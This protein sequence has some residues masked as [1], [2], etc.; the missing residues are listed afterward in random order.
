ML[1]SGR[2]V[3]AL[4]LILGAIEVRAEVNMP[5]T[6]DVYKVITATP[7]T[8][9]SF[10]RIAGSSSAGTVVLTSAGARS[11]TGG[12]SLVSGGTAA[13]AGVFTLDGQSS[14]TVTVTPGA[15]PYTLTGS[16]SGTMTVDTLTASA[17]TVALTAGGAG[18][19]NIGGTLN[20][21][22]NQPAGTYTGNVQV[23]FAYQ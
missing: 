3:A 18:T 1:K 13:A 10:G 16:V 21:G 22:A 17:A 4:F 19:V 5:A 2:L 9:M 23:T 15:G 14:A 7:T 6:V 11:T 8:T 20:V 12:V